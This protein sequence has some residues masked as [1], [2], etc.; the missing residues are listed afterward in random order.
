M[1]RLPPIDILNE[2]FSYNPSNGLVTNKTN[3]SSRSRQGDIVGWTDKHHWL[4]VGIDGKQYLLHRIIWLLHTGNDPFPYEIDHINRIR[5]DNRIDNLQLVTKQD[6]LKNRG[7]NS[8]NKTG[9]PGVSKRR[10]RY[11]AQY[12]SNGKLHLLGT[13]DTAYEAHVAITEHKNNPL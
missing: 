11:K 4:R 2:L 12:M 7:L 9:Y 3:R 10:N 13:Y 1:K 8:N 5:N 6:N